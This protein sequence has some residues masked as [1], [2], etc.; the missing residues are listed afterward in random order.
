M[1]KD[2]TTGLGKSVE[3]DRAKLS[4]RHRQVLREPGLSEDPNFK[5]LPEWLMVQAKTKANGALVK[6]L[7][8]VS[9]CF[10]SEEGAGNYATVASVIQM[11]TGNGQNPPFE[12]LRV[13]ATLAQA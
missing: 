9:G 6:T 11:A 3:A 5:E 10:R 4:R 13:I 2:F 7:L 8:K 1:K 12:V